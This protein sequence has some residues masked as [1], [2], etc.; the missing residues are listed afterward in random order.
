MHRCVGFV[1]LVAH[2]V[3]SFC[4]SFSVES[5]FES[6]AVTKSKYGIHKV[7]VGKNDF[8][9]KDVTV[10]AHAVS[11]KARELIEANGGKVELLKRTTGEVIAAE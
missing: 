3:A 6:N 8:T 2:P 5:L 10:Q 11:A 7:V 4:P 1:V 9:A